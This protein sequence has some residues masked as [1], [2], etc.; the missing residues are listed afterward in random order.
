MK[1]LGRIAA[2]FNNLGEERLQML[3]HQPMQERLLG[4]PPLVLDRVR[5]RGAQRWFA[6]QFHPDTN[7]RTT[8]AGH[9]DL[10]GD[11]KGERKSTTGAASA[12]N[13]HVLARKQQST[14]SIARHASIK[15][16]RCPLLPTQ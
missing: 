4:P 14:H 6:L 11:A 15:P 3:P 16:G 1:T 9:R 2:E 10:A 13:Y 8:T 5:R 12:L 7:A